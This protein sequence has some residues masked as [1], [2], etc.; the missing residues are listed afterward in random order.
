MKNQDFE[1]DY[2]ERYDPLDINENNLDKEEDNTDEQRK[3]LRERW[4]NRKGYKD[5]E[6]NE[7]KVIQE[8]ILSEGIEEDFEVDLEQAPLKILQISK[9]SKSFSYSKERKGFIEDRKQ[10]I[11]YSKDKLKEA[12]EAIIKYHETKEKKDILEA[13]ECISILMNHWV[14]F[15][16]D[17]YERVPLKHPMIKNPEYCIFVPDEKKQDYKEKVQKGV[18]MIKISKFIKRFREYSK[19]IKLVG[20]Y[21]YFLYDSEIEKDQIISLCGDNFSRKNKIPHPCSLE[22]IEKDLE[23][24][25]H[26]A[27]IQIKKGSRNFETKIAVTDMPLNEIFE[28]S[29]QFLTLISSLTKSDRKNIFIKSESS[30]ALPFYLS[31]QSIKISKKFKREEKWLEQSKNIANPPLKKVK[32]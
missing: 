18:K 17:L 3:E 2:Y 25:N 5:I 9:I 21:D 27:K 23:F 4:K 1:E 31:L 30:P 20:S 13:F 12:I 29:I 22:T 28:N 6:L 7:E 14:P 16:Y 11:D 10:E 15:E 8:Y 32:K 26:S 24:V 19:K